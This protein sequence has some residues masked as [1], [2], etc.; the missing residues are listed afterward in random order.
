M[1]RSADAMST[2]EIPRTAVRQADPP[3][4]VS[5]PARPLASR[6]RRPTGPQLITAAIGLL[7]AVLYTWGL[8]RNGM[9]NSY[10][11]AAVRA[12][13][14]SWKAFFFGSIDPGSFITV[15]KPPAAIWVM[16]LSARIFGFSSWSMLLPEAAA[17]VGSV[18]VLH[19]L[20]RRWAGDIAAHL[21]ALAFTLTPVAVLMF[22]FNNPDA[23]LTFLL[24]AAA[25]ALWSAIETGRTRWLVLCGVLLGLAFDT[26]MLQAFLVVP[27][28]AGVYLWTG[29]PRLR[30]RLLQ[31][32]A[33]GAALLVSAG[34]WVA[35]VTL[36]PAA[37]R[38]YIGGSTDHPR[39]HPN[40][41]VHGPGR[42]PGR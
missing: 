32:A 35:V 11:A 1:T 20:V 23:L 31:L 26:K 41:R 30:K 25:W 18:L 27:A 34:W 10:Y 12:G 39:P 29:R 33:G 21:A 8:S 6:T 13:S 40:L 22:R 24:L 3:V 14:T 7:A 2:V 15:D 9:A 36:W 42:R 37:S 16:A 38:P 28:F 19:R 5:P 4:R 17:G